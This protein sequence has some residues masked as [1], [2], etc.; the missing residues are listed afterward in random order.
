MRQGR[1]VDKAGQRHP[2][3]T[4]DEIGHYFNITRERVR[5]IEKTARKRYS[6]TT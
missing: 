1:F 3:M 6:T 2:A 5:Q 4:L